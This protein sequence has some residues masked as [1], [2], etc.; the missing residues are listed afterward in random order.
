[1]CSGRISGFWRLRSQTINTR[2][3]AVSTQSIKKFFWQ[4]QE[5]FSNSH[6]ADLQTVRWTIF[7]LLHAPRAV[8]QDVG[9]REITSPS[10]YTP[11]AVLTL[12]V[13]PRKIAMLGST[14]RCLHHWQ[15][16]VYLPHLFASIISASALQLHIHVRILCINTP[17][18]NWWVFFFDFGFLCFFFFYI[19]KCH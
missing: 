10:T 16:P 14:C 12:C 6:C 4:K 1:M 11:R 7:W 8:A 15:N 9:N 19:C 18:Q 17:L 3:C 2:A 13:S 5:N